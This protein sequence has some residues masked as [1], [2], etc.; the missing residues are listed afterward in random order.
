MKL[1]EK[2]TNSFKRITSLP[3]FEDTQ[4][5][6]DLITHLNRKTNI[7]LEKEKF[8]KVLSHISDDLNKNSNELEEIPSA[9]LPQP[10]L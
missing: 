3:I 1:F 5:L 2:I 10:K 6:N 8:I 9:A 7:E 4:R